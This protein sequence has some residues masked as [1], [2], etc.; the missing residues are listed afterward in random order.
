[1]HRETKVTRN[2]DI[3]DVQIEKDIECKEHPE[4]VVRYYCEECETCVCVLCTFNEHKDHEV[5]YHGDVTCVHVRTQ[6]P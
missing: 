1:M 6:N 5:G 3:F 4:E 2:H